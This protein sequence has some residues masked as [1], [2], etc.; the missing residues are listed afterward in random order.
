MASS[1][2]RPTGTKRVFWP[3]PTVRTTPISAFNSDSW[4]D[5]SSETRKPVA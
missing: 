4:T 5:T 1:A 3:F 2:D